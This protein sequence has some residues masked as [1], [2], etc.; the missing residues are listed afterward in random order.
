MQ[1]CKSI[2]KCS[3]QMGLL[4]NIRSLYSNLDKMHYDRQQLKTLVYL[5]YIPFIK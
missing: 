1:K 3:F 2:N 5:F 4:T